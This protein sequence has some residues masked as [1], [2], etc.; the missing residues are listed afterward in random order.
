MDKVCH[1][2]ICAFDQ[3]V[4]QLLLSQTNCKK[5]DT[6][7]IQRIIGCRNRLPVCRLEQKSLPNV[8]S[9]QVMDFTVLLLVPCSGLSLSL[10]HG[11]AS[12]YCTWKHN[13]EKISFNEYPLNLTNSNCSSI[14]LALTE[15]TN[16]YFFPT[17][18]LI[19]SAISTGTAS[20]GEFSVVRVEGK[21]N[22][23]VVI[24]Y[25][26]TVFKICMFVYYGINR[27]VDLSTRWHPWSI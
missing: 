3:R 14:I 25:L 23:N 17:E 1:K 15:I 20:L 12:K 21:R 10:H 22:G 18:W 24:H 26:L 2:P 16:T 8:I 5:G 6:L 27:R 13:E 7:H 4:L 19:C 11:S 9:V